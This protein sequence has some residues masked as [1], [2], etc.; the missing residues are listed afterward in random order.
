MAKKTLLLVPLVLF[1]SITF[2]KDLSGTY[3]FRPPESSLGDSTTVQLEKDNEGN[4]SVQVTVDDETI[5]ATN[6]SV[7]DDEFS[8]DTEAKTQIGDMTQSWKVQVTEDKVTS[9]ILLDIGGQSQSISL[10]GEFVK[11]K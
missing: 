5:E 10:K 8:F 6:V 1:A 7:K 2:A 3:E 11:K 9:S 4:Y